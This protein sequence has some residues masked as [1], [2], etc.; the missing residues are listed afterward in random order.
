[1]NNYIY[2]T[3]LFSLIIQTIIQIIDLYAL[4]FINSKSLFFKKIL[5][6]E[7]IVNFI[8]GTFYFMLLTYSSLFKNITLA[9]YK[10]WVFS[11]PLMIFTF[12]C[13]LYYLKHPNTKN[14]SD[15]ISTE[16]ITIIIILLLNWIMLLFGYLTELNY[17][18]TYIGVFLGFIPFV[19]MFYMIY[20][21]YV[22]KQNIGSI[23]F[24]YMVV[25]WSLYGLAALQNY[26]IKN[27]M[28]NILDLFSKNFFSLFIAY[29]I[30][31]N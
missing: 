8:E 19:I 31:I 22:N 23:L 27:I 9:R 5:F 24:Y 12:I 7:F 4:F 26:N 18:S 15:I 10:D 3:G 16:K 14:F 13:Y 17:F 20:I 2:N 25:V 1:M 11:T 6:I 29:L 21:N 28:Y 30:I